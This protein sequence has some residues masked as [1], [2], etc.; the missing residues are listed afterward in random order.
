MTGWRRASRV[1]VAAVL[2]AAS[3]PVSAQLAL[4]P[5]R[6][7]LDLAEL[8]RGT[9]IRVASLAPHAVD[10]T[11][12]VRAWD[13]DERGQ[14]RLRPAGGGDLP[15]WLVVNP[16]R[17]ELAGRSHQ[18][19]RLAARPPAEL[20]VGEYRALV[21][22]DVAGDDPT[23]AGR[24]GVA[25]YCTVGEVQR[26][27]RVGRT[28]WTEAGLELAVEATGAG[29]VRPAASFTLRP[30]TSGGDRQPAAVVEGQLPAA[31]VLPGT[32]QWLPLPGTAGLVGGPWRLEIRGRLG[33]SP[34]TTVVEV[35]AVGEGGG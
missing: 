34:V 3:V 2:L 32:V 5:P 25:V 8:R 28:R 7:E 27:G 26:T 31:P 29:H 21:L 4:T 22:F 30:A 35:P 9:A 17:F 1:L 33:D 13:L 23:G 18:A 11:V 16:V 14:V 20:A 10:V 24:Y 6:L 19:V 15:A 12:S